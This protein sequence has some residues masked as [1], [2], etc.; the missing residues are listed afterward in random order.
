MNNIAVDCRSLRW[1]HSGIA[2]YLRNILKELMQIDTR[3]HYFLLNYPAVETHDIPSNFI[4]V[5][6]PQNFFLYKF[7]WT[8]N[9][10]NKHA[11]NVYWSPTQELPLFKVDAC[12][13]IT[14]IH[15][16]AFEHPGISTSFNVRALQ[17]LGLYRRSARLADS[18]F[19]DSYYSRDDIAQTYNVPLQKIVVTY[20]GVDKSFYPIDK[21]IAK[22]NTEVT[23]G[24]NF[25]YIFY[26]NTGKPKNLFTAF[27]QLIQGE[28]KA[29]NLKLVCLGASASKEEDVDLLVNS[30]A[31]RNRVVVMKSQITDS[32]LVNLYAGAAFFVCPSFFEGFGLTP[33][34][35]LASG[36]PILV[37]NVT[38]LPE[39]FGTNAMYCDP[40]SIKDIKKQLLT[41]Y[42]DLAVIGGK[43]DTK[44]VSMDKYRWDKIAVDILNHLL[45]ISEGK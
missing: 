9:F 39:I 33:L 22:R 31:L 28:W 37:S 27:A 42:N 43:T 10:L 32:Q 6:G 41:M 7:V 40:F 25:P 14:T 18:I 20:L 36:T 11:I 45:T 21:T 23:F 29:R 44:S 34:E 24:I 17:R 12:R 16:I 8:P 2:R 13:Y 38:S 3:N 30:L 1:T 35:A 4:P 15:D 19:T 5:T 26:I